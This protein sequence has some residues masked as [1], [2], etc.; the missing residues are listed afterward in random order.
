MTKEEIQK[1]SEHWYNKYKE[2]KAQVTQAHI[3][4][5]NR[6]YAKAKEKLE[7]ENN[8]LLDVINNQDV[9]IIDLAKENAELEAKNKWYSEQVCNK[10]CAEVWGNLTKAKEIIKELLLLPYANNEEVYADVT[11][12]LDKAEQFIKEIEK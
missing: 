2:M 4:G 9:K 5:Y 6:G 8:K 12:T 3:D 11:S 1:N 7:T 10:E